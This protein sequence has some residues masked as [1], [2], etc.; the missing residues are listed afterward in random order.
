MIDGSLRTVV[1]QVELSVLASLHL[2]RGSIE[3]AC[4]SG[5]K[6][7]SFVVEHKSKQGQSSSLFLFC[8]RHIRVIRRGS[9][10]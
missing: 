5:D 1:M 9:G 4:M 3:L 2:E 6:F 8:R 10:L 7:V